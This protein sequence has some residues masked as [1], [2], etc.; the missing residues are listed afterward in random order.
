LDRG[1]PTTRCWSVGTRPAATD[2]CV[3]G[4]G[5]SPGRCYLAKCLLSGARHGVKP[6]WEGKR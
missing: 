5:R 4:L 2:L 3:A 6:W 1:S